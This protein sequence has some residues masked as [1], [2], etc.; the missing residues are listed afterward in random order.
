[1]MVQPG[2]WPAPALAPDCGPTWPGAAP[3]DCPSGAV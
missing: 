2:W 3:P 1:M